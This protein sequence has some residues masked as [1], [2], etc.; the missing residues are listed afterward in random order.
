MEGGCGGGDDCDGCMVAEAEE[1]GCCVALAVVES[2][3]TVE[4]ETHLIEPRPNH[5]DTRGSD[6][7]RSRRLVRNN[8]LCTVLWLSVRQCSAVD[9]AAR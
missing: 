1:G 5:V 6:D 8:L 9:S 4:D 3:V 7:W 2:G